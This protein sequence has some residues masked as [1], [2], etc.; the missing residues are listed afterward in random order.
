MDV[1]KGK[2]ISNVI[3]FD[4]IN[5]RVIALGMSGMMMMICYN[6]IVK[7]MRSRV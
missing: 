4:N 6:R 5:D 2:S 1:S 7:V 3:N